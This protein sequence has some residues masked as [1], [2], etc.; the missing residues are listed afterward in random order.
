[1]PRMLLRPL[2][3]LL[4]GAALLAACTPSLNW[5]D[6]RLPSSR[7]VAQLPCK[8]DQTTRRVP[9]GGVPTDLSV[10]GCEAEGATFAVMR[11]RAPAGVAPD[12]LLRG[13]QQATLANMRAGTPVATPFVPAGALALPHAQRLVVSAQDASGRA[14]AAQ[15]AW[16]ARLDGDGTELIHAVVYAPRAR[17]EVAD[18]F[19]AGIKWP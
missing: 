17:P 6:V 11:A 13:W 5:R 3:A 12:E 8:P 19:F 15:A 14:L 4:V 7:V 2:A 16:A 9:L 18:A 10:V 1:M